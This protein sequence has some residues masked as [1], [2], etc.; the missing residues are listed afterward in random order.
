MPSD[1][2]IIQNVRTNQVIPIVLFNAIPH[3]RLPLFHLLFAHFLHKACWERDKTSFLACGLQFIREIYQNCRSSLDHISSSYDIKICK[4]FIF[5]IILFSS[6]SDRRFST[7]LLEEEAAVGGEA[8][9]AARRF[10]LEEGWIWSMVKSD[11]ASPGHA[12]RD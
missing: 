9:E 2:L 3:V 11:S 1:Y 8:G 7:R 6:S 5:V 10:E 12:G 4:S